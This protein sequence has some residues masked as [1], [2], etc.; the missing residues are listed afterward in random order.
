[1]PTG[2]G[3]DKEGMHHGSWRAEVRGAGQLRRLSPACA[4]HS[5]GCGLVLQSSRCFGWVVD[6][7]APEVKCEHVGGV[8]TAL[9]QVWGCEERSSSGFRL[10]K[11]CK[12][13]KVTLCSSPLRNIWVTPLCFT[14]SYRRGPQLP[15]PINLLQLFSWVFLPRLQT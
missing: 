14:W 8:M 2:M 1:M 6:T 10:I 7:V 13:N 4:V 9:S 15:L 12:H 5:S 11:E 3:R